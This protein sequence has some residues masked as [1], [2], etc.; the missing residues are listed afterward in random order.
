[1]EKMEKCRTAGLH[2]I[3]G[4]STTLLCVEVGARGTASNT[5]HHMCKALGMSSRESKRLGKKARHGA[6]IS[7]SSIGKSRNGTHGVHTC[8]TKRQ[9]FVVQQFLRCTDIF[10]LT[11]QSAIPQCTPYAKHQSRMARSRYAQ[12]EILCLDPNQLC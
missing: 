3:S 5:F 1:M 7:S 8:G 6:V 11:H 10:L 12:M 2:S 9:L 4:W